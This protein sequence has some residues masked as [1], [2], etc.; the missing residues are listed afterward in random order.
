M[1]VS[2]PPMFDILGIRLSGGDILL[3]AGSGGQARWCARFKRSGSSPPGVTVVSHTED[4]HFWEACQWNLCF[5]GQKPEAFGI[6]LEMPP[7]VPRARGLSPRVSLALPIA[8][9]AVVLQAVM[10]QVPLSGEISRSTNS[11]SFVLEPVYQSR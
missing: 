2:P 6:S 8:M 10:L 3:D 1:V 4:S 9:S 5:D 11:V 7:D